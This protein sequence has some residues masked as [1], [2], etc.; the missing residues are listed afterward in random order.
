MFSGNKP[1]CE[2]CGFVIALPEN[3]DVLEVINKYGHCMV[4]GMGSI[5]IQSIRSLLELNNV[6]ITE[7][8]IYKIV[9]YLTTALS[10][11]NEDIN[12]GPKD[13]ARIQSQRQGIKSSKGR[14]R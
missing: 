12:D 14:H 11:R 2:E 1:D 8:N 10:K 3:Y 7:L 9:I 5:N 6:Y 4:D 13:R